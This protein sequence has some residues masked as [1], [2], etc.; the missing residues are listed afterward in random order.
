MLVG[1]LDGDEAA[2]VYVL[3]LWAHCQN[4]RQS[5]FTNLGAEALKALCRF[6]GNANKLESSLAASGFV[7]RDGTDLV[8]CNWDEYNSSLIAAW[9]NGKKGGRPQKAK[10]I[11]DEKPT[12]Y[13][14]GKPRGSREEKSREEKIR[15]EEIEPEGSG[16]TPPNPPSVSFQ[17]FIEAW[18]SSSETKAEATEKRRK[19]F[20]ARMKDKAWVRNWREAIAKVRASPFCN[21]ANDRNW[22]ATIDWFLRPDTVQRAIEGTYDGKKQPQ[23][24]RPMPRMV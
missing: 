4:R 13:P 14:V 6:P 15:N 21:G 2:P 3:R 7:R 24:E 10:E 20:N 9:N 17:D 5:S 11:S 12:G 18:N 22:T 16:V 1:T 23:P 8:V 19:A